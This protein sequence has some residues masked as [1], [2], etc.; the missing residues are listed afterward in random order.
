MTDI[1]P[2]KSLEEMRKKLLE[3]A[4]R[5][6]QDLPTGGFD[7][8]GLGIKVSEKEAERIREERYET[9]V[10]PELLT[11]FS[12]E[13]ALELIRYFDQTSSSSTQQFP[14]GAYSLYK[15]YDRSQEAGDFLSEEV[16]GRRVIELGDNGNKLNKAFFLR[17]G[18]GAY[19]SI[20]PKYNVDGLTHLMRQPDESAVVVSFGVLEEGVLYAGFID[21]PENLVRYQK[22][23]GKQIYRATPRGAITFHGLEWDYHLKDAGF[24]E[25]QNSPR[26]LN[27]V[28]PQRGGFRVLRKPTEK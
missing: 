19:E 27:T 3:S 9:L 21:E 10:T 2:N 15:L 17:A 8:S 28:T 5:A 7:S 25:Y 4:S 23:L 24:V 13:D 6:R 1:I 26:E 14:G 16:R 20:D 18:A 22:E 11:H 12:R